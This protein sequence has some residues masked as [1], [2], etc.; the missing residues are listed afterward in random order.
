[1]LKLQKYYISFIVVSIIIIIN[2][3]ILFI[4][5]NKNKFHEYYLFKNFLFG[6]T[7][8][9]NL[10]NVNYV[11]IEESKNYKNF[12]KDFTINWSFRP[13]HFQPV[14]PKLSIA[15]T[16]NDGDEHHDC[17]ICWMKSL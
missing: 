13:E 3:S 6:D 4:F 10:K 9:I 7:A 15:D 11:V 16:N 2:V 5:I 8:L 17:S 12:N 1:M 14:Y